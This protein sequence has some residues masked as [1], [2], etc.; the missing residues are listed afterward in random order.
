MLGLH[1]LHNPYEAGR[2]LFAVQ[3]V[4]IH[5][6][7]NP[8]GE[9]FDANI[10]V[11]VLKNQVTFSATIQPICLALPDSIIAAKNKGFVVGYGI[12]SL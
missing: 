6:D 4:N 1:D 5:P 2:E 12:L 9:S 7:W 3:S 11:L 10:A 8:Q